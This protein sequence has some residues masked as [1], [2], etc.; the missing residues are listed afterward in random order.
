MLLLLLVAGLAAYASTWPRKPALMPLGTCGFVAVLLLKH[1][2]IS[3]RRSDDQAES[4]VPRNVIASFVAFGFMILVAWIAGLVPAT[5]LLGAFLCLLYG[6]RRWWAVGA[7]GILCSLLTY[8]IF[9]QIFN[10]A[11]TF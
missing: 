6:E 10:V 8:S 7:V 3:L 11:L 9:G 4:P 1:T 2:Y 5:G